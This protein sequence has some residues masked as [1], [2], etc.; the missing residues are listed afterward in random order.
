MQA[1]GLVLYVHAGDAPPLP[2]GIHAGNYV[3]TD[4]GWVAPPYAMGA[5]EVTLESRAASATQPTTDFLTMPITQFQPSSQEDASA[6]ARL[7][8]S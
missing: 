3:K 4:D 7:L 1:A 6:E 5:S 8:G 2:I